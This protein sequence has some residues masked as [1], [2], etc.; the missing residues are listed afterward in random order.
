VPNAGI[1]AS[2]VLVSSGVDVLLENFT[3][4]ADWS[5]SMTSVTGGRTGNMGQLTGTLTAQFTIPAPDESAD[6]TVG[7]A[8]K[9][10][11]LAAARLFLQF[12]SDTA[13]INHLTFQVAT[14][15]ALVA[16]F[17]GIA[18]AIL[19]TTATGLITINT[20]YYIEAQATLHDT[21]GTVKL[22]VNGA[23][24]LD[25][26]SID[27]KAGGTKAVFDTVRIANG[28]AGSTSNFEDMYITTGAGAP[29]KGDI[30]VP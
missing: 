22:R 14:T 18:G 11:S 21:A 15:G 20:W 26:N 24:V 5:G 12:A 17:G 13:T 4:V 28:G 23:T 25:L 8:Y 9:N 16:R 29:F 27:T 30:T 3:S 7:L 6:L 2:S 19:G 1:M 10:T